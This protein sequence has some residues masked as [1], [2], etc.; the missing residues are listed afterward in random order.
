MNDILTERLAVRPF[1]L[2]DAPFI[3]KLLNDP[4]FIDNI[5]DKGVKD[6]DDARGYLRDGPMA[7]Y[8][9][10]GFGLRCVSLLTDETPI[11]MAGLLKRDYLD[12]I[13]IGYALL[14]E[15][16]RL[17]Y[18]FEATSAVMDYAR[19]EIKASCVLAIVME[20]N[21]PS[22]G[23]LKKLGFGLRKMIQLPDTNKDICLYESIV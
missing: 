21:E 8:E 15:F 20:E 14:P 18:A 19:R 4:S 5:G 11:G 12:D 23:L 10:Y 9:Q 3:L 22:I 6:L 17:G 16:C 1:I 7:S 2:D 13:D